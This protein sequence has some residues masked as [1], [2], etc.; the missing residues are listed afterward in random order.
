MARRIYELDEDLLSAVRHFQ[1]ARR[2]SSEVEAVRHLIERG[3]QSFE[4]IE[5]MVDRYR[6]VGD[7]VFAGHPLVRLMN[8]D[9]GRVVSIETITGEVVSLIEVRQ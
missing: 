6:K 5:E 4:T 8:L 2:F 9:G 3:V 1:K 7:S